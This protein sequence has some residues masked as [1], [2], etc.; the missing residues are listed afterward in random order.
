[1]FLTA[2][3]SPWHL[4]SP[5]NAKLSYILN[6]PGFAHKSDINHLPKLLFR[7]TISMRLK[8]IHSFVIHFSDAQWLFGYSWVRALFGR[9]HALFLHIYISLC[10]NLTINDLCL[11]G[12]SSK[13]QKNFPGKSWDRKKPRKWCNKSNIFQGIRV[14][15]QH[16]SHFGEWITFTPSLPPLCLIALFIL[17]AWP[18]LRRRSAFPPHVFYRVD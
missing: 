11:F 16:S 18:G 7:K 2:K 15:T 3:A 4:L 5:L 8:I 13:V 1:M 14:A 6:G 17:S 12:Q 10:L 9:T